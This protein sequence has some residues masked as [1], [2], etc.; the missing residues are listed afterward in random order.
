MNNPLFFLSQRAFIII[1][2]SVLSLFPEIRSIQLNNI[3]TTKEKGSSTVSAY[4]T[5]VAESNG[6]KAIISNDKRF[7][8]VG[9][10]GRI[11]RISISGEITKSEK[12]PEENFN[13][14]VA[15]NQ[16]IIVAGDDGTVMIA[17]E[18]GIFQSMDHITDKNIN[19]LALFD[20][21]IIAGTDDG[22]IILGDE[23]GFFQII[24]LDL[25]GNI[26]SLSANSSDCFGVTDNGEI[27]HS[28]DAVSWNV[29]DFNQVYSGFYK[30]CNFTSVA[31]TKNRI[32]IAGT[33]SDGTPA[34]LFSTQG[35]VW[36]ER[37]LNY[38]DEQGNKG[39]LTDS[40]NDILY[41]E[42]GDQFLIACNK[43]KLVELPSCTHCNA[44]SALSE[45]DLKGIACIDNTLMIVGEDFF[46]KSI[47]IR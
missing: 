17:S 35:E 25:K 2:G 30:P 6:Y 44:L 33:N 21:L 37:S 16:K 42:I 45:K 24:D 47:N 13:C 5:D 1:L 40:P 20:N 26:V 32:A 39:Y 28:A 18:D 27:I 4:T 46:I 36:T 7:I 3:E 29:F 9:S 22:E 43:G 34:F 23:D 19:T 11:D 10:G 31:V 14:L 15:D 8:A 41:D 12:F 38:T